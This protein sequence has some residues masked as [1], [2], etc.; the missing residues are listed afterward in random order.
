MSITNIHDAKSQ[1]SQ[2]IE[3]AER[4]EEVIIARAGKPV[5][6][7]IPYKKKASRRRGGQWSGKIKVAEDFDQLPEDI[8][9][10]FGMVAPAQ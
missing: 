7:L 3:Q 9:K 4:G 10:A 6:K 8:G 5:A 1:L 2:L